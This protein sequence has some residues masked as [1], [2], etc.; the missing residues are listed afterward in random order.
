MFGMYGMYGYSVEWNRYT[1][2]SDGSSTY[3][4]QNKMP[5]RRGGP[6]VECAD[7]RKEYWLNGKRHNLN[8]PAKSTVERDDYY[9]DGQLHRED[10]PAVEYHSE[11][12][13]HYNEYWLRGTYLTKEKFDLAIAA[14]YRDGKVIELDGKKYKLT[15]VKE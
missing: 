10:G 6:A 2:W 7:G 5:S 8:G 12:L 11:K 13:A 3:W 9:V 14:E 1:V 4:L 15:E